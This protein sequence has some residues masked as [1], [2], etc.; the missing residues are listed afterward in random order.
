MSLII[1][2][3]PRAYDWGKPGGI[4]AL[5]GTISRAYQTER[6]NDGV[7]PATDPETPEAELWLG[8]HPTWQ[9]VVS[10]GNAA[11]MQLS[12]ALRAE[13]REPRL[14]FLLKLLAVDKPLSLQVHPDQEQAKAGFDRD[15][16]AGLSLDAS[17]RNYRDP[18]A[19]P[20]MLFVL[21][22]TFEL[23]A[24]VRPID[25]ILIDVRRAQRN[26][27]NDDAEHRLWQSFAE[28][29]ESQ[30]DISEALSWLLADGG[31]R[32]SSLTE[33]IVRR[34]RAEL[35]VFGVERDTLA[36]KLDAAFPSDRGIAVSLLLRHELLA[37]GQA[38]FLEPRIPHFYIEG[39]GIELMGPSD[40][41][42]RAG[43]THKH[44]DIDE[45]LQVID[46]EPRAPRHL[47]EYHKGP[48]TVFHAA[49]AGLRLA[50][51]S[52]ENEE[53][54]Q[55]P[56]YQGDIAFVIDGTLEVSDMDGE[57][58]ILST[59]QAALLTNAQ[60]LRFTAPSGRQGTVI[61]AGVTD[62]EL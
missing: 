27:E 46:P 35:P 10:C 13:G 14:G 60:E 47:F 12:D 44:V 33:A 26:V 54:L 24:G 62:P 61:L 31:V 17:D 20:E 50:H 38:I 37:R 56:F 51:A 21:S 43:L 42:L 7:F 2:N 9:S 22:D 5:R 30:S 41:V 16:L 29:L 40:N 8:T 49:G 36:V 45:L 3:E 28:S 55:L 32:G 48:M 19:K 15:N 1:D 23:C 11:G 18:N 58:Q 59:G 52:A 6:P 25:E 39:S 34:L 53:Q 4:R 57:C